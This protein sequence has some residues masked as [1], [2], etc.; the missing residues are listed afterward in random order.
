[1]CHTAYVKVRFAGEIGYFDFRIGYLF[2][3]WFNALDWWR[4]SDYLI[5]VEKSARISSWLL[6]KLHSWY[7]RSHS[8]VLFHVLCIHRLLETVNGQFDTVHTLASYEPVECDAVVCWAQQ[9]YNVWAWLQLLD[10][11]LLHCTVLNSLLTGCTS[12]W[13][14]TREKRRTKMDK[15][16]CWI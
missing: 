7:F 10:T 1:M 6:S 15:Y 14:F 9:Q 12:E 2:F 4:R 16:V 3:S 5:F 8:L 13:V 11:I